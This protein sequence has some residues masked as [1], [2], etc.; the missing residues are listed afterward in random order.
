[1]DTTTHLR[2]LCFK[3]FKVSVYCISSMFHI[4]RGDCCGGTLLFHYLTAF[5]NICIHVW[6]TNLKQNLHEMRA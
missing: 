5:G 4:K 2:A 1:M 6:A 3:T